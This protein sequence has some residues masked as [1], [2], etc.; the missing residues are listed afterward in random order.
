MV[1]RSRWVKLKSILEHGDQ[2]RGSMKVGNFL[3]SATYSPLT[4]IIYLHG[5]AE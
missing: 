3:T 5:A 4:N 2:P 1:I